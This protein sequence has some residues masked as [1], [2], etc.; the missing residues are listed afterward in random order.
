MEQAFDHVLI[1]IFENEFRSYVMRN[2][3]MAALAN[4]GINLEYSY[5]VMHPSQTNYIA[6]VTGQLCGVTQ[7]NQTGPLGQSSIV[8]LLETKGF[9]WKAYIEDYPNTPWQAWTPSDQPPFVG[10]NIERDGICAP[11]YYQKHNPFVSMGSV[12]NSKD[13]WS[14]IQ[15]QTSPNPT[16]G[17]FVS[18]A[19][20]DDI[21]AGQLPHFAWF[22]PNI[23]D[24][25]HY[26]AGTADDAPGERA[27][28][29]VNQAA[30]WL[31]AF[32]ERLRFRPECDFRDSLLPPRT[33]VVVTYDEGDFEL[34]FEKKKDPDTYDGPNRIYTVLLGDWIQPARRPEGYNHYSLLKTIEVNFG[35]GSLGCNDESANWYRFLWGQSFYWHEAGGGAVQGA[36]GNL[37]LAGF[38]N[39]GWLVYS[40]DGGELMSMQF[41][42]D[43]GWSEALPVGH[44]CG[45][46]LA[47]SSCGNQLVLVYD[48]PDR[49]ELLSVTYRRDRG[50]SAE[51]RFVAGGRTLSLGMTSFQR[52]DCGT[53]ASPV[54]NVMLAYRTEAG[55]IESIAYDGESWQLQSTP[56]GFR[57]DGP[58][59]L[60]AIGP[61]LYLIYKTPGKTEM[62]FVNYNSAPFNAVSNGSMST[63][64]NSWGAS[65]YPVALFYSSKSIKT[66]REREPAE[67]PY[68]AVGNFT[69]AQLAGEVHLVY[70][71]E[72]AYELTDTVF[73]L[74][75]AMVPMYATTSG[76]ASSSAPPPPSQDANNGY[77]TLAETGWGPRSFVRRASLLPNGQIALAVVGSNLILVWNDDA[78]GGIRFKVG[79]YVP[80]SES[81]A[82]VR[83]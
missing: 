28:R 59:A 81:Q 39:E 76:H 64:L 67:R 68:A 15:C 36:R 16:P 1:V 69:C 80:E 11:A 72:V 60:S 19:F 3:Y 78:F 75:G 70:A 4:G 83:A 29:L 62:S 33:L 63:S 47:L 37:A 82:A 30:A 34:A 27:P 79:G 9:S 41:S 32:F 35:L 49:S 50:W 40:G 45:G 18:N 38:N 58:I 53:S 73:S 54:W 23:W 25:G 7:D 51:P 61:V 10:P 14:K 8:D 74:S 24:D 52:Y 12:Q 71:D 17:E 56:V 26:L 66:P 65:S 21:A 46:G 57:T 55:A 13:R 48:S 5:G 22:T 42:T 77:G 43:G 2:S 31:Q 20:W 44:R 6:A